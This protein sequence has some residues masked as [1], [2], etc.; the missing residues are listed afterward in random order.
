MSKLAS[1]VEKINKG[2]ENR[3]WGR[4]KGFPEAEEC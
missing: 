2:R 1:H 4:V 3:Y